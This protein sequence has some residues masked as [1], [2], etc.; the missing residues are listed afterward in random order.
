MP[1]SRKVLIKDVLI[2]GLP[3]LPPTVGSLRRY[4]PGLASQLGPAAK[5]S[6]PWSIY[7][8]PPSAEKAP[9]GYQQI[10]LH[11]TSPLDDRR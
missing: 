4:V 11:I 3:R 6:L 1:S 8:P 7:W 5:K 10:P 2:W 9:V